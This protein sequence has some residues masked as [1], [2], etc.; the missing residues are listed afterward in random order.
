M[1]YNITLETNDAVEDYLTASGFVGESRAT[2]AFEMMRFPSASYD[3]L[4]LADLC[5]CNECPITG[6][7][8]EHVIDNAEDVAPIKRLQWIAMIDEGV[9]LVEE[10]S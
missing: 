2:A 1:L 9:R 3:D 6:K 8:V 10:Q 4:Y 7:H 5:E